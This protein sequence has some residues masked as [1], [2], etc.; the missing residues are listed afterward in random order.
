MCYLFLYSVM[1]WGKTGIL[2]VGLGNAVFLWHS[3]TTDIVQLCETSDTGN[4]VTSVKWSDDASTIAVGTS[5]S[6]LRLYDP[7]K[8]VLIRTLTGHTARISCLAWNSNEVSSGSRDSTIVTH[9][10]RSTGVVQRYV[11]HEEE[12]CG[13][14]YS[15]DRRT[16][17][18]GGNDNLLCIWSVGH[19]QSRLKLHTHTAAVKALSWCPFETHLL[20]SGGG[21]ADRCIRF[22]N[23][24]TGVEVSN[25]DTG[26]QVCSLQ[27][28]LTS[29]ELLSA[30]GF[31][32]NHLAVWRY[33]TLQQCGQLEGHTA[34]VLHTAMVRVA[35]CR[36]RIV[37]LSVVVVSVLMFSL[38]CVLLSVTGWFDDLQ[39]SS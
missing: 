6:V 37:L 5:D 12:I 33:P 17:A 24:N 29:K 35:C 34:R 14:T 16:L 7:V 25:I 32:L 18:S 39:C 26:S 13:L 21:S 8:R 30:H 23:V 2:A 38:L 36:K 20:A 22:H 11:G 4:Y 9:D 28:S 27:W 19:E 31:A 15:A 10:T 1:D 3:V